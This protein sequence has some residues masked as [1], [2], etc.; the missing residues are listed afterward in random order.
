ML[1]W[2]A[3][4][5]TESGLNCQAAFTLAANSYCSA[6]GAY[7]NTNPVQ[8]G[9][10]WFKFTAQFTSITI[11]ISGAG[12]GGTL[13]LPQIS[14]YSGCG[15]AAM[16][17]VNS[18]TGDVTTLHAD[19]LT[20]GNTYYLAVSGSGTGT[21]QI[22]AN[23]YKSAPT[24][25]EDCATAQ[26]LY[27]TN[28]VRIIGFIGAGLNSHESAGTC[29]MGQESNTSWY[30][31][32]ASNNGRLV[33]TLT[34][35][36]LKNDIDFVLYDLG[37]T[38]DCSGVTAA[39][40]IRCAAGSGTNCN[41]FYNQ[42]G[43][44]AASVDLTETSGCVT[45]Q[46][47][48]VKAVDM[49]Q[50]HIY[51]LLIN[52]FSG[53]SGVTLK[54]TDADNGTPAT[55]TFGAP[56]AVVSYPSTSCTSDRT[57]IFNNYLTATNQFQWNFG[58]G[59]TITAADALGNFTVLYDSPG[60]RMVTLTI[61][62]PLGQ[63]SVSSLSVDVPVSQIPATPVVIANKSA[64]CL[65]DTIVLSTPQVNNYTYKWSG[66]ASF[67]A[68]GATINIPVTAN[69]VS[70]TYNLTAYN[71]TCQSAVVSIMPNVPAGPTASFTVS[72]KLNTIT[73]VP[74]SIIFNNT[75]VN[76]DHYLW[77][78]GDLATS[79][80]INPTHVYNK[81]GTYK[82]KLTAYNSAN[83]AADVTEGDFI[84]KSNITLLFNSFTPNGDNIN[85]KFAVSIANVSIFHIQ[86]FNR[87]GQL[88]FESRDP[89]TSWDG[90]LSG[91][92]APVGTYYYIINA[93]DQG[94]KSIKQSGNVMLLR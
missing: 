44:A 41:P 9:T 85:D 67:T 33:F 26:F 17:T 81:A 29:L 55:G 93:V 77:D 8:N 16:P 79:T 61:T 28:D 34:P 65:G 83:C 54:F 46:D 45:G 78:F 60:I 40:A 32:S 49:L 27:N 84:I 39:N 35:D 4:A 91:G 1:P 51:G 22:C 7:N 11:T 19:A 88:V 10:T 74:S 64:F 86:I 42:T 3:F 94:G 38:G 82:V 18:N 31:W 58:A 21:F 87:Y 36:S 6:R 50:G 63:Q 70:G 52:N 68:T 56:A 76:A 25:G 80:N 43:L 30:K 47:G 48:K 14:L 53:N 72:V 20:V 24:D 71:G 15:A 73:F 57:Y 89:F 2:L 90:T 13:V 66:P 37:T 69:Y 23:N 12:T 59:A 75:S 92:P 62:S 5:Q